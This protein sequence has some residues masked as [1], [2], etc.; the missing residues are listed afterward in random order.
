M[1]L[2]RDPAWITAP[3]WSPEGDRIVVA[4]SPRQAGLG[5]GPVASLGELRWVPAAGG[6]ASRITSAATPAGVSSAAAAGPTRV[7]FTEAMPN[8][9]PGFNATSTTALV[10]VRFDGTDK[11]THAEDHDERIRASRREWHPTAG[12]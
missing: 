12:T 1:Q 7:F 3:R 11:R 10:S 2:T 8:P 9:T 4:W 5:G 6:V